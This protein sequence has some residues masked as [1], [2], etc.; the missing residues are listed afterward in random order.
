MY[1][2]CVYMCVYVYMC[3]YIYV[4]MSVEGTICCWGSQAGAYGG[5]LDPVAVWVGRSSV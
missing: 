5:P 3:I 2:I 1:S 4:L